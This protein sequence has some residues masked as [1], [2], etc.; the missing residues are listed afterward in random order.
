MYTPVSDCRLKSYLQPSY[1]AIDLIHENREADDINLF[2]IF[3][4]SLL[5]ILWCN[6]KVFSSCFSTLEAF[7]FCSII[8][9]FIL[10][11]LQW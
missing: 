10:I 4:Q 11:N 9:N 6:F 8:L 2:V 5:I 7:R 1:I 3:Y